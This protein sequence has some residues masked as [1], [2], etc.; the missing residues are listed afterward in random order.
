MDPD[1]ASWVSVD[2]L[3]MGNY[4]F[5]SDYIAGDAAHP[6]PAY[7]FGL[8]CSYL[9]DP[10][11]ARS[12]TALFP[13]LRKAVS[14]FYNASDDAACFD[15]PKYPT[16]TDPDQPVIVQQLFSRCLLL[17]FHRCWLRVFST[18]HSLTKLLA[19]SDR[20]WTGSGTGSKRPRIC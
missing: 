11:L 9:V 15:L 20:R 4:P 10:A 6:L 16:A 3:A 13:A 12:P 7:P 18:F 1:L 5:P 14:V 17:H 2:S 8:A 19:C